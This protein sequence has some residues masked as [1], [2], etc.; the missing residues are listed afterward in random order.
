MAVSSAD[1]RQVIRG[2]ILGKSFIYNRKSI[3]PGTDPWGTP[4]VIGLKF[5]CIFPITILFVLS[6]KYDDNI[7]SAVCLIP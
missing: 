3:G 6:D 2:L 4:S 5:E 7:F 1:D